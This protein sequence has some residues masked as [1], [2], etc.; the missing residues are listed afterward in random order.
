MV[1]SDE[2]NYFTSLEYI[3]NQYESQR[4]VPMSGRLTGS[5]STLFF[6]GSPSSLESMAL[7][8]LIRIDVN[9]VENGYI[10]ATY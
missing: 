8:C 9:S 5:T 2:N 7:V 10:C 4:A 3:N 6:I 1:V